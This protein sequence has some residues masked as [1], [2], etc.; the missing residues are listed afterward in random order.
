MQET[1]NNEL[2]TEEIVILVLL[3]GI[4]LLPIYDK[5]NSYLNVLKQNLVYYLIILIIYLILFVLSYI[6]YKTLK[7]I[8]KS[9]T[10]E[11]EKK[12]ELKQERK[13]HN[14]IKQLKQP[15]KI[16][17]QSKPKELK[18]VAIKALAKQHSVF[19]VKVD[20]DKG[21][22]RYSNLSIDDLK[23]L[24]H[25]GYKEIKCLNIQGKKERYL[26]KPR[27]NES[28][29]HCFLT[30]NIVSYLKRK[31]NRLK[32]YTSVNPDI[33]FDKNGKKY[34]LEIETGKMYK[35]NK[36]SLIEKVNRLNKNYGE[37][38][39]FVLTDWNLTSKY[40]KLGK[41]LTKRNFIKKIEKIINS[42]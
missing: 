38:W 5:I 8:L 31:V 21:Y 42:T 13:E 37:D 24:M 9:R 3:V 11:I 6:L 36:K 29:E 32:I 33:V 35:T 12:A 16:I 2:N 30:F 4:M 15:L 39:F 10:K 41:I 19:K 25:K 22:F 23:Y 26:I 27:V 17:E 1:S 28:L 14:E 34:A 40:S 7:K 18:N 20:S